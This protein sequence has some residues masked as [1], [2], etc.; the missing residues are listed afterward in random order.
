ME[1]P[2]I[3]P[4]GVDDFKSPFWQ[5]VRAALAASAELPMEEQ[6]KEVESR[7]KRMRLYLNKLREKRL[8]ERQEE[9]IRKIAG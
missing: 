5:R 7:R 2:S 8:R 6:I 1:N 4:K 3:K 9:L